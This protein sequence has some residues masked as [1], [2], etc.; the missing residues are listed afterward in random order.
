MGK[1]VCKVPERDLDDEAFYNAKMGLLNARLVYSKGS[2]TDQVPYSWD[3]LNDVE[4]GG[5]FRS[6]K[7]AF[8]ELVARR[9]REQR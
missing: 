2:Y 8:N 7:A 3:N 1:D 9:K 4:M 6:P 5:W